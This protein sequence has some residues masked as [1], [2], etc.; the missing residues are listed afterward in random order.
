MIK[1]S[2]GEKKKKNLLLSSVIS[3]ITKKKIP[4]IY[5]VENNTKFNKEKAEKTVQVSTMY[6]Q[7]PDAHLQD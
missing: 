3:V 6:Q 4:F 5:Q 7:N 2:P 1:D